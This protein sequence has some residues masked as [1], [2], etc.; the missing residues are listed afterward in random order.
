MTQ[1]LVLQTLVNGMVLSLLY[2]LVAIGLTMIYGVMHILNWA[3]GEIVMLGAMGMFFF[4]ATQE[5]NFALSLVITV[6]IVALLAVLI[7]RIVFKPM[8]GLHL[9]SFI[10]SMGLLYVLQ[11][12]AM[13]AFGTGNR[14]L[15][16]VLPGSVIIAGA[17]LP[18]ERLILI[19]IAAALTIG[20]YIFLQR[21]KYG[22][23]IRA[24]SMDEVGASLQGISVNRCAAIAMGTGGALA[25]AAG[26]LMAPIIKVTPFMGGGLVL[27]AFIIVFVGGRTSLVGTILAS[28]LIG[29]T[30]SIVAS[31]WNPAW[32]MMVEMVILA[33]VLLFRPGGLIGM[34]I[35]QLGAERE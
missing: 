28:F 17:I 1:E 24:T 14:I 15:P 9:P 22:R 32:I 23:A 8:R 31:Y 3:H 33:L 27:K 34:E 12:L 21:T 13:I 29:Y 2:A 4:V 30:E 35:K 5:L 16:T 10:M 25:G 20:Y 6:I 18:K 26:G 11:T 7:E 19:P